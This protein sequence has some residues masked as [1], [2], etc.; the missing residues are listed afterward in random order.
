MSTFRKLTNQ[1][2]LDEQGAIALV[3]NWFDKA[4][5][6]GREAKELGIVNELGYRH[7]VIKNELPKLCK[8]DEKRANFLFLSA[9][10]EKKNG[11]SLARPKPNPVR[12]LTTYKRQTI[13]VVF[14]TGGII[15]GEAPSPGFGDDPS[16]VSIYAE[17]IARALRNASE[18]KD[19][20]C[21]IFR[22]ESGGGDA[23]A[24][25]IINH[26]IERIRREKKI[27]VVVSIGTV[28]ASGG[29]WISMS[30]DKILASELSIVGS[31]GVVFGKFYMRDFWTKKIGVTFDTVSK[32]KLATI[33]SGL[34]KYDEEMKAVINKIVDSVYDD[35]IER[36]SNGRNI[37][38]NEVRQ[39]A[40]GKVYLGAD[41]KR[42]NLI[43]VRKCVCA[44]D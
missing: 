16:K 33:Q 30:A 9:Y 12:E 38:K 28:A 35:F 43:D 23:I 22:V 4:G 15:L 41:A 18:D 6:N 19:V 21:I 37:D 31:I 17:N 8:V 27:K 39:L 26:E 11:N 7:E 40:Q 5:V 20:K 24:S 2:N 34:H 1:E 42:L 25:E 14:A 3:K 29:Y 13:A 36:V 10:L 32:H 44:N